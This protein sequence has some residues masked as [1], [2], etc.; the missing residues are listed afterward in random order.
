[1]KLKVLLVTSSIYPKG[2]GV[3]IHVKNIASE[4]KNLGHDVEVF[5]INKTNKNL[6]YKSTMIEGF[7]VTYFSSLLR[8]LSEIS[9]STPDIIHFHSY[10][11]FPIA[12]AIIQYFLLSHF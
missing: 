2:G 4:L 10:R 6:S 11:Y 3:A 12:I 9:K 8:L 1:M 7:K 5:S